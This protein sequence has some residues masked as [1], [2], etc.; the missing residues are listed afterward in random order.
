MVLAPDERVAPGSVSVATQQSRRILRR[1]YKRCVDRLT[2][3]ALSSG[4]VIPHPLGSP[5]LRL[6]PDDFQLRDFCTTPGAQLDEYPDA[7]VAV[8][9]Y[10]GGGSIEQYTE[11]Q[12]SKTRLPPR[13]GMAL[14]ST[15]RDG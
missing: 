10:C 6:F 3:S 12:H 11:G 13:R 1:V 9:D 2:S 4:S 15:S 7:F 14:S 8:Q 5:A